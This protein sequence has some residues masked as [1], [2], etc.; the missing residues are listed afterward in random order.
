ML[1]YTISTIFLFIVTGNISFSQSFLESLS[2]RQ[3]FDSKFEQGE[4]ATLTIVFPQDT[5]SSNSYNVNLAIGIDLFNE[6]ELFSLDPTFELN[7]NTLISKEQDV[8]KYGFAFEWDLLDMDDTNWTPNIFG[9]ANYKNDEIRM[10]ESLEAMIYLTPL[11]QGTGLSPTKFYIPERI[12]DLGFLEFN[13]NPYIGIEYENKYSS[14]S[15]TEEGI[16]RL[17]FRLKANLLVLPDQTNRNLSIAYNYYFRYDTEDSN[18]FNSR[19]H[20]LTTVSLSYKFSEIAG[21]TNSSASIGIDY[22]NGENPSNGFEE[23]EYFS[24]VLKL[25]Y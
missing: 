7:K 6:N 11:F 4:P 2:I 8:V 21:K 20:P 12:T 3:S 25:K 9:K 14:D 17:Y 18:N 19:S 24:L 22:I 5:S 13:Y 23:Q 1:K 16:T 15:E 10:T